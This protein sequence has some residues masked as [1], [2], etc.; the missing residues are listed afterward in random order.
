MIKEA[1]FINSE[2]CVE[3]LQKKNEFGGALQNLIKSNVTDFLKVI[4]I[5]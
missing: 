3:A 5:Q 2:N 4:R 1:E